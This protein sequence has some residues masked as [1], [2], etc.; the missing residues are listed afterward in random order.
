MSLSKQEIACKNVFKS[1]DETILKREFNK[2]V[3]E[4]INQIEKS[5]TCIIYKSDLQIMTH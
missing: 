5:K 4:L 1:S 3:I 2:K